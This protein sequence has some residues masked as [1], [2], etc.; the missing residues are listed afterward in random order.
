[1]FG[2]HKIHCPKCNSTSVKIEKAKDGTG[3]EVMGPASMGSVSSPMA[4]VL[5]GQSISPLPSVQ[6]SKENIVGSKRYAIC[7][8]CKHRFLLNGEE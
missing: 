5:G 3:V 8:D 4:S 6:F 1:M 2:H 7:K